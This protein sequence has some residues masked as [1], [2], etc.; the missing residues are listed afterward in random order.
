VSPAPTLTGDV[1]LALN[2]VRVERDGRCILGP[3][4]WSIRPGEFWVVLGANGS[5]KSTLAGVASLRAH[6][7][8]GT[9]TVL[10]ES[11]GSVD[12]RVH[13]RSVG[14]LSAELIERIRSTTCGRDVVM[15]ALHDALDPWWHTYDEADREQAQ[16]ALDRFGVGYLSDHTVGT[17]SSGELQRCLLAR[18]MVCDPA[19][20]ILD[21]PSARLDL[22][23]REV[24]IRTL[25]ECR[26]DEHM[27]AMVEITHHVDEIPT[28]ATHVLFLRNGNVV[29]AGL[30][31][32][33]LTDEALS[34]AFALPLTVT[35]DDRGRFSARLA[36]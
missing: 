13:R 9:V 29:S 17:M 33:H 3:V 1:A 7:T 34:T 22:G 24:L 4:T 35:Q 10:G 20:V 11:L 21:E 30:I 18:A 36:G 28:T 23:G 5:G 19:V 6:P 26:A 25:D 27:R 8:T 15:T 16:R 14:Y 32:T 2:D 12:L 31:D